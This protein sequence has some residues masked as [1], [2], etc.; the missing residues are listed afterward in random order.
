MMLIKI[1]MF[2]WALNFI[3]DLFLGKDEHYA[4]TVFA[5]FFAANEILN[6]MKERDSNA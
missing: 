4:F 5:I 6:Y 2:I 3:F 1:N